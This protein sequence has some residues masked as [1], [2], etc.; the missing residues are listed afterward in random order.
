VLISE[1]PPSSQELLHSQGNPHSRK[2]TDGLQE[3]ELGEYVADYAYHQRDLEG[4]YSLSPRISRRYSRP[5]TT[6]AANPSMMVDSDSGSKINGHPSHSYGA[7]APET[8]G[9]PRIGPGAGGDNLEMGE[10]K[11]GARGEGVG[12]GSGGEKYVSESRG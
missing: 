7:A 11:P 5:A 1:I 6:Q 3:V 9:G 10:I 4:N 12:Y 2:T 8:H